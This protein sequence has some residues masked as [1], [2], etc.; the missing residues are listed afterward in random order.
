MHCIKWSVVILQIALKFKGFQ[1]SNFFSFS[2]F[3]YFYHFQLIKN[4]LEQK[5]RGSC[6]LQRGS[7]QPGNNL[8]WNMQYEKLLK[9]EKKLN[10][11]KSRGF[12]SKSGIRIKV[13]SVP[14][15]LK[16][17]ELQTNNRRR[18]ATHQFFVKNICNLAIY[19]FFMKFRLKL[20]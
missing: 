5:S 18:L 11:L 12:L 14:F 7:W 20:N 13:G 3:F 16:R 1:F 19:W 4:L 10:N 9:R 2:F 8:L 17:L 6:V 15:K